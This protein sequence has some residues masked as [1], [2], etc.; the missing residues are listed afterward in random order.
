MGE[1]IGEI[2]FSPEVEQ[3]LRTRG[4]RPTPEQ[5]REAVLCG[6]HERAS[7]NV[8]PVYGR[9]LVVTGRDADGQV[10]AFLRPLDLADGLWECLTAWRMD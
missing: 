5:V 1:W 8:H 9:R 6:A 2:R 3:K 7:W 4:D 10:I